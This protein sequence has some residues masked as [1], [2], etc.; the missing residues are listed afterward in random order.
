MLY[1]NLGGPS[2]IPLIP[3]ALKEVAIR[4]YSMPTV[5]ADPIQREL[6]FAIF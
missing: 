4:P 5:F 3:A 1:G 2:I 6:V